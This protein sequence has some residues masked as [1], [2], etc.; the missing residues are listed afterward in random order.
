VTPTIPILMWTRHRRGRL[1]A[2]STAAWLMCGQALAQQPTPD[3]DATITRVRIGY[4]AGMC[5]GYCES[6]TTVEP[7]VMRSVSRSR[8]DKKHYPEMKSEASITKEDW[9]DLLHFLDAK[10]LAA[11]IGRIGCPGCADQPVQWAEV[12]YS[13]GTKLTVSFNRGSAPPEIAALF[14]KI[15]NIVT[16]PLPNPKAKPASSSPRS[17]ATETLRQDASA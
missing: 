7:G 6:S 12:E 8:S 5:Q 3:P 17:K 11:F 4:S 10:V 2:L 9:L 14:T 13:D 16:K 1:L 15:Q